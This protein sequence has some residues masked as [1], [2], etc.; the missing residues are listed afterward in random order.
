MSSST[1]SKPTTGWQPP[2]LEEMQAMLPQ[3]QFEC[4]LGR[5]GMGAVYKA[6]QVSLDRAVAIKVLPGDLIDNEDAQ[7]AERFKN[8]ARTMAKMN[9]PSIVNVYDFG[10]TNTGL[11]Y[12]VMEF[13]DGTDV[14]KMIAVQGKLPEDYALSI[15]AH[16]CDALAYAHKNGVIH[17][18][19]KPANILINMEGAV[20]VADFGLAKANDPSQSGIT[21]TNMAMG[22]PDFV[23]PEAFVP[24]VP[25]D[26]RADLYAIGVMLYQMLTGEIPRGIWTLPGKKLGTDPRF[27]SI[28]TKAMQTDRESRYQSAADLRR[29]LDTILVTPRA[30]LIAQ[31][32]AAAEAAARATQAQ[33]QQEA[34]KDG[35]GAD[36]AKKKSSILGPILGI[37]ASIALVAGLYVMLTDDGSKKSTPKDNAAS[38]ST[39]AAPTPAENIPVPSPT[40]PAPAIASATPAPEPDMPAT[41]PSDLKPAAVHTFGG[42]RYLFVEE[43]MNWNEAKARAEREGGHLATVTT[44]EEHEWLM[45]TFGTKLGAAGGFAYLGATLDRST[46]AWRWITGEPFEFAAW[47]RPPNGNETLLGL[48]RGGW[49]DFANPNRKSSCIIEWDDDGTKS[50]PVATVASTAPTMP[51]VVPV[52]PSPAPPVTPSPADPLPPGWTDLLAKADP[53]QGAVTGQWQKGPDGLVVKAQ[54]GVLPFDLNQ[55]PSEQYDFEMDFTV[56]SSEPDVAHILPLP[57]GHWFIARLSLNHC[58]LGPMLDGQQPIDRKEAYAPDARL[59]QGRRHRSLVQIRKDSVR[60]VLDEKEVIVFNG[61]LKRLT[62]DG[63]FALRNT[64]NLGIASHQADVTFHRIGFRPHDPARMDKKDKDTLIASDSRLA[65]FEAGFQTRYQADA[66]KPFLAALAKLNQSY[67]ANGIARARSAAQTKGSFFEVTMLD[68]E[69]TLI[70]KGGAVPA[71]DAAETPASLK[72]LRATYRGAFAI[73][74]TERDAKAA[75]LYDLYLR[76]IDSYVVELTKAGK[77]DT[78]VRIQALRN[79]IAA[80]KPVTTAV[81]AA[82]AS[83]PKTSLAPAPKAPPAGGS[84]WRTAAEYLVNN[85]GFFTALKNG[86]T[87]PVTKTSEIPPGRFDIIE[88]TFERLG[89]VLPPAKDADFAAFNGLRDLR[90]VHFRPMHNGLSDAAFA[91]LAG[92]SELTNL[93]FEGANALTD[94]VLTHIAGLKKLDFLAIQYAESFTGQGFDKIAGAASITNLELM[95]SGITDEGMRAVST[96][97]KL[98]SFRTTSPKITAAGFAALTSLKTLVTLTLNGT[99]FDDEGASAIAGIPNLSNLDVQTTKLTDAGLAKLRSLKKLTSLNLGGTAVTLEAAAEF[100]KTMPQCRVNR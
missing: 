1:G 5:G 52:P 32:Q 68:A 99:T 10:E 42:H 38:P 50:M 88:L 73:I 58:Y 4:L 76:A 95:G 69:K 93:N 64:A 66:E 72:T 74:T 20:K 35:H 91:F 14:S 71:D 83:T 61:D 23:A 29:D 28:I 22:T 57:G 24:G 75:P 82:T 92:N 44:K 70:E 21:K 84:S 17:R 11:L 40:P 89:S 36:I 41:P 46:G 80:Q 62:P 47:N 51:A 37:A 65:Q 63:Q 9:H 33:K 67:V 26:G 87:L 30:A 94:G 100:Q 49:D 27:D 13:I 77:T 15:T 7:F 43:Q 12:I 60:L 55:I 3:Y 79:D 18:D 45:E 48:T 53:A 86:V 19:I 34:A 16:V 25:L 2:T 85:G 97:K 8:E 96:F 56:H 59:A 54:P 90:R 78:A 6:L 98:Q 39:P 81:A 31:Q